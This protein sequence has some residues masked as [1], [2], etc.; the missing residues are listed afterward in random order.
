MLGSKQQYYSSAVGTNNLQSSNSFKTML[1]SKNKTPPRL[2]SMAFT[3][4]SKKQSSNSSNNSLRASLS[5]NSILTGI[6][7]LNQKSSEKKLSESRS[8]DK[9]MSIRSPQKHEFPLCRN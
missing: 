1:E 7:S 6:G 4:L 9:I 8:Q 2:G 5:T 3:G